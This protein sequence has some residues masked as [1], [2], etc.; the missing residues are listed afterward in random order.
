MVSL[1]GEFSLSLPVTFGRYERDISL[2]FANIDSTK[3]KKHDYMYGCSTEAFKDRQSQ[4]ASA[5]D[6][7]IIA[8]AESADS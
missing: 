4:I 8:T 7:I 5:Y 2:T 3:G 1:N 6:E